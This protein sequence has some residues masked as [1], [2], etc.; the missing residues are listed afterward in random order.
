MKDKD[1]QNLTFREIV[2]AHQKRVINICYRFTANAEDAEDIAQDV[3]IEVYNSLGKFKAESSLTTWIYRI[4]VNKSL[5]YIKS[6]NRK[7]RF[8]FARQ[9]NEEELINIPSNV[10]DPSV[11]IDDETRRKIL[12]KALA[13]LPDKQRTAITL[14]KFEDMSNSE[15]AEIMNLKINAVDALIFRAKQNLQKKLYKYYKNYFK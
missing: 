3:F 14:N 1:I 4:A 13:E 10:P 5:D 7:K 9:S 11:T 12:N 15:I 8:S 6:R 2:E